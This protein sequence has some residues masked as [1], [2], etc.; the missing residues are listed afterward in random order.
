MENSFYVTLL[1]S[2]STFYFL[3]DD[4][5]KGEIKP[6]TLLHCVSICWKKV[7]FIESKNHFVILFFPFTQSPAEH[8]F[9]Y[10]DS[11]LCCFTSTSCALEVLS[12]L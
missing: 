2:T 10:L 3:N 5:V 4:W 8:H 1:E 9:S 11:F 6:N 12:K 7:N